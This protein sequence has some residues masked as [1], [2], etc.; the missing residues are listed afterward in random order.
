MSFKKVRDAH[1]TENTEAEV[2]EAVVAEVEPVAVDDAMYKRPKKEK[3]AIIDLSKPE[4]QDAE[5]VDDD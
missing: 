5:M 2:A 1:K 4:V 3:E